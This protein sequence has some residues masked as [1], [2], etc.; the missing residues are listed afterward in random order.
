MDTMLPSTNSS[1]FNVPQLVKDG[2]NWI[3]YK[4]R[5]LTVIGARGLMRYVDGQATKPIPYALDAKTGKPV[6]PNGMPLTATEIKE[7]DDKIDEFYQKDSLVKQQIFGMITDRLLL[8]IQKLEVS[9]KIWAE[10]ITQKPLS[11]YELV[12]V[13]SEEYEHRQ[14]TDRRTPKK[15]TNTAL[16]AKTGATKGRNPTGMTQA[17]QDITCFNCDRKG[18][19]K[20]DCWRPGGGKEGQGP[21]QK[22]KKGARS[23]KHAANAAKEPQAE[24][25]ENYAF[26]MS[27]LAGLAKGLKVPA[28]HRGAIVN[29]GATLHFCPN[30]RKFITFQS[31]RPQEIYTADG[32]TLSAIG[33]GDVNINLPLGDKRMTVVLKDMLYAPKMAFTLISANCIAGAGLA[34]HF[35]DRMCRILSP[36]PQHKVIVEIPQVEGLY[37]VATQS[38][39]HANVART[40]LTVNELH[41]VLGHISQMA[42]KHAIS[43]V[44]GLALN[45]VSNPEFCDT[46]VKAKATCQTFPQE[47]KNH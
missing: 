28:D 34:V 35:K 46:C 20:A 5:I 32:S 40:K 39:H 13:I 26:A 11:P 6:K 15:G 16:T 18:H 42:I 29:S 9:A 23:S 19:Y 22:Q 1:L 38:M 30:R 4:E 10:V 3:T 27:D 47:L 33:R 8:R 36:G 14:L 31:I 17:N 37:A 2:M 24:T 25:Q 41:H 45:T 44:D 7:L 21:Q 43:L 12:N